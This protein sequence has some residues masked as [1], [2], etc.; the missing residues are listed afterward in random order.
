MKNFFAR[1]GRELREPGKDLKSE[2]VTV[3]NSYFNEV[4]VT[5][6]KYDFTDDPNNPVLTAE[7]LSY[8]KDETRWKS[9]WSF[10]P[11]CY[12]SI[13]EA[14]ISIKDGE[15]FLQN[16]SDVYNNFFG[17]QFTSQIQAIFNLDPRKVKIFKALFIDTDAEWFAPEIDV[18]KSF[19][20]KNGMKSRL[21][22]GSFVGK[23]GIL[24]S[25]IKNDLTDPRHPTQADALI[26]GR[27]M[28][29][30]SLVVLFESDSEEETV[31]Y[32]VSLNY[33]NS[34]RSRK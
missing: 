31:L 12:S 11:E 14:I 13:G 32:G 4:I 6:R 34:E 30:Q 19:T 24:Y 28:R 7:T 22:K 1:K 18:P 15:V 21:I 16:S 5:F 23:E 27:Q 17:E 33:I 20:Y 8:N 26:N 2:V 29:G 9:F 25:E 3:F 10:T